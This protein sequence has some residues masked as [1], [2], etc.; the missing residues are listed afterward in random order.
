M[1]E[2]V[3]TIIIGA[4]VVG[5]AI[6][7]ALS[8]TGREVMVLE[9]EDAFGTITSAR[10]SEVIHA[11]IYY[12]KDSLKARMCVAGRKKLYDYCRAH[13][14]PHNNCGKLIVACSADEVEQFSG[15]APARLGQWRRGSARN[16]G[17]GCHRTGTCAGLRRGPVVSVYRD[18]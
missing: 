12:A 2:R 7:R 9:R 16:L 17:C 1:T 4:G 18:R 6:A 13:G 5:L 15:I 8:L 14:I 3:Q 11:G 10:N